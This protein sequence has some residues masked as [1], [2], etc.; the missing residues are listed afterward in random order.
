MLYLSIFCLK[1]MDL[2]QKAYHHLIPGLIKRIIDRE[3]H[4]I[5][6]FVISTISQ[7]R[8]GSILLDAGA[9]ECRFRNA[10]K[11][12]RYFGVDAAWGD[13]NWNY[14]R[15]DVVGR[16]EYLPFPADKF[17][18]VICTEVLEHVPEPQQVLDELY[19]ILKPGGII[20]LTTPQG[21]GVHQEPYD[22]FRFTCYGLSYLFEKSG[23]KVIQIRPS[24]GYFGYLANR[25]TI[26]PKVLFWSITRKWLRAILFPLEAASYLVFV[27]FLPLLLN[28]VDPLD[29]KR[30]YTLDYF[31]VGQKP[32]E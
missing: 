14:S 31:V 12:V 19:R 13:E 32:N 2:F 28:A 29:R 22:Y 25:L 27:L 5:D 21:W 4:R 3:T 18:A 6:E 24:S 7:I 16:I 17:D 15:I 8:P 11:N 9:G 20:C 10:L 26:L 23:F 30:Q 1:K